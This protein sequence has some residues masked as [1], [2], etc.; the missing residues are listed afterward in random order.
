MAGFGER[1]RVG[2]GEEED[3][4]HGLD[5][6]T[7]AIDQHSEDDLFLGAGRRR[8]FYRAPGQEDRLFVLEAEVY[9]FSLK[10][11][12]YLRTLLQPGERRRKQ[13]KKNHKARERE[14]CSYITQLFFFTYQGEDIWCLSL[15]N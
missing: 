1:D 6:S 9:L 2:I 10:I 14:R 11:R 13:K 5:E 4:F 8:C 15:H 7:L 3:I 12:Q